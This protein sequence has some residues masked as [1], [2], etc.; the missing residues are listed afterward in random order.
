M[1][2]SA[3]QLHV[4]GVGSMLPASSTA[5]TASVCGPAARPVKTDGTGQAVNW[6]AP[7]SLHWK[8]ASGSSL[9]KAKVAVALVVVAD[10][11]NTI[12]VCGSVRSAIV[13]V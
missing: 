11:P 1:S 8:V 10:G 7:S 2:G 5:R 9:S 4:A 12:V 6:A 3:V 13:Q